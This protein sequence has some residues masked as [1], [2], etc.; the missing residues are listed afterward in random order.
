MY[1]CVLEFTKKKQI[2]RFQINNY[3]TII[4]KKYFKKILIRLLLILIRFSILYVI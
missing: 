2:Y 1:D 3:Y 4:E